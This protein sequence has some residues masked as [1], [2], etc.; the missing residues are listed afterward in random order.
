VSAERRRRVR[1]HDK[2]GNLVKEIKATSNSL[3][4]H[5]NGKGNEFLVI[6]GNKIRIYNG[7]EMLDEVE[8]INDINT[9]IL[10]DKKI[11]FID[12]KGNYVLYNIGKKKKEHFNVGRVF[13]R[14]NENEKF[15]AFLSGRGLDLCPFSMRICNNA[16]VFAGNFFIFIEKYKIKDK[17]IIINELKNNRLNIN[18][19]LQYN[20][21]VNILENLLDNRID[22]IEVT[23]Q[24]GMIALSKP[25]LSTISM[26]NR[27]KYVNYLKK[28]INYSKY[29]GITQVLIKEC[30][31]A[32]MRVDYDISRVVDWVE[33]V[34]RDLIG[35]KLLFKNKE[36]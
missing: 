36:K 8:H 24:D 3:V 26:G 12:Y 35:M 34:H 20:M 29:I 9:C 10:L 19:I 4:R 27:T 30:L 16:L 18:Y 23:K 21:S 22:G 17:E 31:D 14:E 11:M 28:Y 7:P 1:I 33:N 6:T 15:K 32:G 13:N 25:F 2:S 5:E